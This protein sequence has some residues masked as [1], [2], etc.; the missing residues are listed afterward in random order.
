MAQALIVSLLG[1]T[2]DPA[3]AWF[4]SG[5]TNFTEVPSWSV[6]YIPSV[7]GQIK[8]SV[9]PHIRSGDG[10]G[11]SRLYNKVRIVR[12][13][14]TRNELMALNSE[15]LVESVVG[16]GTSLRFFDASRTV[17][18]VDTAPVIGV[19]NKYVVEIVAGDG[20]HTEISY[21]SPFVL[22]FFPS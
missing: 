18:A 17:L 16:S 21:G 7:A 13:L 14:P 1:G 4:Y 15:A 11:Y 8:L 12:T 2:V 10:S 6:S 3:T 19:T 9:M 5:S 22:E 20:I